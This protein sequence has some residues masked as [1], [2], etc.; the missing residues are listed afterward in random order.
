MTLEHEID[1]LHEKFVKLVE[2]RPR[3]PS[4]TEQMETLMAILETLLNRQSQ[5]LLDELANVGIRIKSVWDL[6]NSSGS[7]PE[8]IPIL[9]RY[10]REPYFNRTKEGIVRALAVKEA[11]GLANKVVMEEYLKLPKESHEEP[12]IFHYRWAFGNTMRIIVT[13]NDL[14]ELIEI[15][16][17]ETN[18]DSR[19]MFVRALAKLKSPKVRETLEVLVNDNSPTVSDEARKAL[20]RKRP[21][22]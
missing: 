5:L 2:K 20:S 22:N 21:A 18:G 15:V 1:K 13:K 14:E 10:L 17:D 19:N 9:V 12:W 3:T 6:V 4:E 8:A 16:L 11:K 7:Y